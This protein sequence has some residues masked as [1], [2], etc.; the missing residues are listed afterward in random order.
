MQSQCFQPVTA[1]VQKPSSFVQVPFM[2]LT[3][4]TPQS[5]CVY[6]GRNVPLAAR[7]NAE[8]TSLEALNAVRARSGGLSPEQRKVVLR[9]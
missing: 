8:P 7:V 9:L 2:F 1:K 6:T 5:G 3:C 4:G